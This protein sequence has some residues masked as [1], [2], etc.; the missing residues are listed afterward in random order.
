MNE[1]NNW[2]GLDLHVDQ[3]EYLRFCIWFQVSVKWDQTEDGGRLG[4]GGCGSQG[5]LVYNNFWQTRPGHH[6]EKWS[7]VCSHYS[8]HGDQLTSV[9]ENQ[10]EPV[11]GKS[12][13]I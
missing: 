5:D 7:S 8:H 10:Y 11:W 2:T 6:H 9:Q 1:A 4:D 12:S 13:K 3:D